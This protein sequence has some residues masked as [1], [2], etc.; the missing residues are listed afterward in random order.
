MRI[1]RTTISWKNYWE[2]SRDGIYARKPVATYRVVCGDRFADTS[3]EN[4][5]VPH[6]VVAISEIDKM[7]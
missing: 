6:K 7:P 2:V 5:G 1:T 4:I 3:P